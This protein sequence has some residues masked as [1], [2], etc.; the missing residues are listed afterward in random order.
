MNNAKKILFIAPHRP[1]RAPSQRFRFEQYL[2]FLR[3][4]GFNCSYSFLVSARDDRCFY[5]RGK[6]L[7]KIFI[8]L[9]HFFI[10]LLNVLKANSYDII[11]I[12]RESFFVGPAIFEALLGRSKAKLIFDFDD[13]IWQKNIS[14]ANKKYGFLKNYNKTAK[15]ISLADMVFAGNQHLADYAKNYNS[16]VLIVPTT[17]DTEIYKRIP[18][19]TKSEKICIGWSGSVSTIQ[20]F[21]YS[22]GFLLKIKER[23]GEKIVF[24]V[25]GGESYFNEKL[26]IK[27]LAWNKND[28]IKELSSFDIGIMP[29]PDDEWAR[30]KCGLKGLQY[31]ALAIPTIMS[32]VG[33]NNEIIHDGVNGFLAANEQEWILKLSRLIE[34]EELR[35]EIGQ[36]GR[37]TVIEWYSVVSQKER[38]LSLFINF[39]EVSKIGFSRRD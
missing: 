7:I 17:I 19:Q 38:Y 11:F 10:R 8:L 36:A 6:S 2:N 34:S 25:I 12:H 22:I 33:V 39:V 20:H 14:E 27:G 28:E 15:I 29:L 24:K 9:K 21:E 31:M 4:R 16:N 5:S 35:K 30:G 18:G 26:G 32:P 13:S 23:F 37:Q 3:S 1:E